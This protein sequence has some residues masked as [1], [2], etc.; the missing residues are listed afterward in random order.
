MRDHPILILSTRRFDLTRPCR[1]FGGAKQTLP[2]S[3]LGRKRS[4]AAGR[5][6]VIFPERC[7]SPLRLTADALHNLFARLFSL[8]DVR[9]RAAPSVAATTEAIRA[10]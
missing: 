5:R 10:I 9:Y 2:T 4:L 7:Q 3:H 1:T 6:N 8:D